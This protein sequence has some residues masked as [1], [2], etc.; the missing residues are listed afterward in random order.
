MIVSPLKRFLNCDTL[1]L[2]I[3]CE[4]NI[5]VTSAS[6]NR[7]FAVEYKHESLITVM[8]CA[9]HVTVPLV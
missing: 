9:L 3:I 8:I 2:I 1:F 5:N 7:A 4:Q 6:L